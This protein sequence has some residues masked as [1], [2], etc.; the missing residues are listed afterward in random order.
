MRC[1][2]LACALLIPT[3]SASGQTCPKESDRGPT[4]SEIRTL[5]GRL[6]YHDGLRQWFEL[7]L[8]HP[9]CGQDSIQVV[10][11]EPAGTPLE[12]FRGCR[13]KSQGVMDFALTGYYSL[14]MYQDA[15]VIEPVGKCERQ[16]PSPDYSKAKPDKAVRAYRVEM[17]LTRPFDDNPVVFRVTNAGKELRPWQAYASY[18]LTGGFVLYGNCGTGFVVD[19]VS[20]TPEAHPNHFDEPRSSGDMAMFDPESAAAVGKKDLRLGYTCVRKESE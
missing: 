2:L 8:D 4:Q 11:S 19:K 15:Q 3:L 5:E 10:R 7:K 6:V 1:C 20:G 12:V 14:P 18:W 13:V 9:E 16:A 17:H